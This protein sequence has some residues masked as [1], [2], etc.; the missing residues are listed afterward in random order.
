M[1]PVCSKPLATHRVAVERIQSHVSSFP[2]PIAFAGSRQA[3]AKHEATN[4]QEFDMRF[5]PS[6]EKLQT[7]K[8]SNLTFEDGDAEMWCKWREQLDGELY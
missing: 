1:A 5:D 6:D 3:S 4:F 8:K 2:P 7:T